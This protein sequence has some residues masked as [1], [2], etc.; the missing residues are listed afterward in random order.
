MKALKILLIA[1]LFI[2]LWR[3]PL[4]VSYNEIEYGYES[5]VYNTIDEALKDIPIEDTYKYIYNGDGN[6]VELE[7]LGIWQLDN[8]VNVEKTKEQECKE[9]EKWRVK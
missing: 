5:Q 1:W 6:L 7:F 8:K 3:Y 9:V 4:A 2:A